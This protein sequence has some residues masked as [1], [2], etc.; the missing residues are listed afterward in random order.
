MHKYT[1][2]QKA[3]I[4]AYV[5]GRSRKGLTDLF[6]GYFGLCLGC[7]QITAFIKNNKLKTGNDGR[8]KPGHVPANKGKHIG[9]WEPTQFEKGHRPWNYKP[10][11]TERV[12]GE[13]YIDVKIADPKK[14]KT[15]HMIVW[16]GV[17][18]SVPKG[19]VVIFADGNKRNFDIG[20]LVL[21]SR[22]ELVVM[23]KHGLIQ[24]DADLTKTGI[25]IAD[26][27]LKMGERKRKYSS[28]KNLQC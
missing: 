21:V 18:G 8:F 7:N 15:K 12:N 24:D 20:N 19:H 3:F 11:G 14:W 25:A 28:K 13:G 26:I 2:E 16:E 4:K 27:H 6:N 5:S 9:G 22:K 23:N 17:N 1:E 10:V